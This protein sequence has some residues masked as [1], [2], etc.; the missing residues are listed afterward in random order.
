VSTATESLSAGLTRRER[1]RRLVAK[2][3]VAK[4]SW[5]A[6]LGLLVLAVL[7][8]NGLASTV[9]PGLRLIDSS[10]RGAQ[11]ANP[12][13]AAPVSPEG[14]SPT[15]LSLHLWLSGDDLT[16]H[17]TLAT[18]R[19]PALVNDVDDYPASLI[20]DQF[21]T[22]L[23][24]EVQISEHRYGVTG[25]A[26]FWKELGFNV[27][28]LQQAGAT[29]TVLVSSD[30]FRVD[31]S[32]QDIR[33][34]RSQDLP[35]GATETITVTSTQGRISDLSGA[36]F[37]Q[38]QGTSVLLRVPPRQPQ[39]S[40]PPI[41]FVLAESPISWFTG[42]RAAGQ[43]VLPTAANNLLI[44]L[45]RLL[46]YGVLLWSLARIRAAGEARAP[47]VVITR[48][49]TLVVAGLAVLGVL[50][51]AVD[52]TYLVKH[53]PR[54][55]PP[56]VAGPLGLFMGLIIVAWPAA[57]YHFARRTPPER[58][59]R[60]VPSGP[61]WRAS[62]TPATPARSRA[63]LLAAQAYGL[64]IPALV[65]SAMGFA[66]VRYV[67]LVLQISSGT[68]TRLTAALCFLAFALAIV[69]A[70]ARR[71]AV[72]P[73][74]G[75]CLLASLLL[76]TIVWPVLSTAFVT[77]GSISFVN[78]FGKWLYLLIVVAITTGLGVIGIRAG[79]VVIAVLIGDSARAA[80]KESQD[81]RWRWMRPWVWGCLWCALVAGLIVP[82]AVKDAALA[83]AHLTGSNPASVISG[84]DLIDALP[85]LLDWVLLALAAAAL[86]TL[87]QA[88][89][90]ALA[91]PEKMS[92][93]IRATGIAMFAILLCQGGA[94]MYLPVSLVAGYIALGS[95]AIPASLVRD[96]VIARP[97]PTELL[98]RALALRR[99]LEFVTSQQQSIAT[100]SADAL[101]D[102]LIRKGVASYQRSL[103]AAAMSQ[104][105]LGRRR[106]QLR[107]AARHATSRVFDHEGLAPSVRA[108]RAGLITGC[109]FA[110]VPALV[111]TLSSSPP[112]QV[113]DY[114][115]LDFLG[116]AAWTFLLWPFL[117]WCIGYFL[118][119]IHGDNGVKK[120]LWLYLAILIATLPRQVIYND[121]A[122]W[123]RTLIFD[124][125]LLAFLLICA[126]VTCEFLVLR[127]ADL[128]IADWTKVHNWRFV[129]TWSSTVLAALGTA[130]ATFLST[131]ATDLG[132]QAVPAVSVQTPTSSTAANTSSGG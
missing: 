100:G 39:R 58:A 70:A 24:G 114:P 61:G 19:D 13:T 43:I 11:L 45:A 51:A 76:S 14:T 79:A 5:G 83:H 115:A 48:A 2:L 30:V 102:V 98:N 125:E 25:G 88:R 29:T 52:L 87:P 8:T 104:S 105:M 75:P 34:S 130:A 93:A 126:V 62:R 50:G 64:V 107:L 120:A 31:L 110:P 18:G 28:V 27:P 109:A 47:V 49:V 112:G 66:Y 55:V 116:Q 128:R 7:C 78:P 81:K 71:G 54:L 20:G 90:D 113:T 15:T 117:G 16:A 127:A 77:Y 40:S 111:L 53:N 82:S 85:E 9:R 12:W 101:R 119:Y 26:V 4:L 96:T 41:A 33:I 23:L 38:V 124:L 60:T 122:A 35:R 46:A 32:Y 21:V 10:W 69:L 73:L 123:I 131:A 121:G 44:R 129:V 92:R 6:G 89:P 72:Q 63:R 57:V 22:E 74:L 3:W 80:A 94:W 99:D 97:G 42:L 103:R 84:N 65:C 68:V 56:E 37:A 108:A 86:A 67:G 17:Y 95:L 91:P 36:S 106:D 1:L 59:S 118:P 132:Q